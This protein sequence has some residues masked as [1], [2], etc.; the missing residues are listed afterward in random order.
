MIL[1]EAPALQVSSPSRPWQLLVLSAKTDSALETATRNL[2]EHLTQH[3]D[4]NLA[5]VAHTLQLGRRAFNHRRIVVCQDIEDAALALKT[6]DP[7]RVLTHFQEPCNRPIVFMFP[8]QGA[9]YVDMG[10]ELYRTEPMFREQV[11]R[12]SYLAQPYLGLDLR[13]LIYPSESETEVAAQK[14]QQTNITQPAL[15]VVEY[16]LAQLWMAWGISP[17]A[18]LG[19]SVGEY[20]AACLAGVISLEDALALVAMRGQLMQQLP[21]G[22][23]LAVSLPEAEV[24]ALLDEKLSLAAS[25]GPSLCVVSGT[26]DA[27]DAFQDKILA[28]DIDCRRLH[29]SHAFHSPMM[30]PILEPFTQSVK[31]SN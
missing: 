14:L 8:G 19:H 12:C 22:S 29:T 4:L 18:M 24:K 10:R 13:S 28:K 1:E 16:A 7:Q 5:D 3:P 15:F 31:K 11:D 9:Q 23:M 17:Q 27:V 2:A 21:T 30:D 26:H 25:N 20:V 6:Q